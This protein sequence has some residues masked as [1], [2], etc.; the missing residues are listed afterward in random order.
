MGILNFD[1]CEENPMETLRSKQ[2]FICDMD[3]V[4][5]IPGNLTK[6]FTES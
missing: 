1:Y 2:G 3:G 6:G 4:G 5:M